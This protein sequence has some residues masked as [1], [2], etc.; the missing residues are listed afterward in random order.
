MPA[1]LFDALRFARGSL[2][3]RADLRSRE[4]S[5][6]PDD[7]GEAVPATLLEP[8]GEKLRTGWVVLH[9]L[10]RP[11]REHAAL[12][13]FT[14]A[15]ASAGGRVLV[16]EIAE[17]TRMDF[18]P[19]RAQGVIRGSVRK[20]AA[21]PGSRPGGV[22]L[23]GFSFGAPQ[24]LLVGS[25]PGFGAFLRGI[26]GWGGY[27]DLRRTILFQFTGNH[28]WKG[29]E[30][31]LRPD[32]YGRW[33]VGANALRLDTPLGDTLPVADALRALAIEAGEQQV[34]A[35][36]PR[37]E[38]LKRHLRRGLP[39]R[40]RPLY[41][42]FVPPEGAEPDPAGA[43]TVVEAM[44]PAVRREIPLLDPL[45]FVEGLPLPIRLLHPRTDHLIPFTE[46]LRLAEAL[47]RRAPDLE[48][49]VTGLLGHSGRGAARGPLGW[50]KEAIGLMRALTGIFELARSEG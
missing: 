39:R 5:V 9:G 17:W 47:E 28:E 34:V 20:L 22:V 31:H 11:G 7:G 3:P 32:P 23:V 6:E 8:E 2:R 33:V 24:A 21:D 50:G 19:E 49:V 38:G 15:V 42:I 48:C 18:A 16:P 10:T 25:D 1:P 14:A 4:I 40:L 12:V 36:D 13:R 41:D 35:W 26:V 43:R 29:E 44:M 27:A 45:R 37:Y 46:S 30:H